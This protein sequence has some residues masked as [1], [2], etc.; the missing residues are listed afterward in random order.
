MPPK[1]KK[2]KQVVNKAPEAPQIEATPPG[3]QVAPINAVIFS[4]MYL[5]AIEYLKTLPQ[6]D[7]WECPSLLKIG[8]KDTETECGGYMAAFNKQECLKALGG[9]AK[10]YTSAIPF[11]WFD[12]TFSPTPAVALSRA[13]LNA[14]IIDD[15]QT[16]EP[17]P[18]QKV[19]VSKDEKDFANLRS[20]SP[21]EVMI[22][23]VCNFV[24]RH[25]A[26]QMKDAD[27][28]G[29]RRLLYSIP[30]TFIAEDNKDKQF[31]SALQVRRDIQK[32]AIL[33][34]RSGSQVVD[35]IM[36][37]VRA[38]SQNK[39]DGKATAQSILQLY[40][41]NLGDSGKE[42]GDDDPSIAMTLSMVQAAMIIQKQIKDVAAINAVMVD[43]S[44]TLLEKSPFFTITNLS[45][46]AKK[47]KTNEELQWIIE[48]IFDTVLLVQQS[49]TIR[50]LSPKN[51]TGILDII[52][53]QREMKIELLDK[54]LTDVPF[55]AEQKAWLKTC[56]SSPSELRS[57]IGYP[58]GIRA[59]LQPD[60]KAAFLT[61][62]DAFAEKYFNTVH[63]WVYTQEHWSD[64]E[65][66]LNSQRT[67]R[68][69][70]KLPPLSVMIETL[71]TDVAAA[72]AIVAAG[73]DEEQ[74][75][76]E[77]DDEETKQEEALAKDPGT[78]KKD[79]SLDKGAFIGFRFDG[80]EIRSKG[81][82]TQIVKQLKTIVQECQHTVDR[83]C[84][85]KS[86]DK[87]DGEDT[88]ADYIRSSQAIGK[89]P[90]MRTGIFYEVGTSGSAQS[91]AEKNAPPFR[92]EHCERLVRGVLNSRCAGQGAKAQGISNKDIFFFYDCK[93][94]GNHTKIQSAFNFQKQKMDM[95]VPRTLMHTFRQASVDQRGKRTHEQAFAMNT[96]MEWQQCLVITKETL[97]T[98]I[99]VKKRKHFEGLN[100]SG[101]IGFIDAL[102]SDSP[103]EFKATPEDKTKIIGEE[104]RLLGS[105]GT[106]V[107]MANEPGFQSKPGQLEPVFFQALPPLLGLEMIHSYNLERICHLTG[108]NG[109][110]AL[111][112]CMTRT[113]GLFICHTEAHCHALRKHV[114]QQLFRMKQTE[115]CDGIY[116][117]NLMAILSTLPKDVDDITPE[118]AGKSTPRTVTTHD[119]KPTPSKAEGGKPAKGTP[120]SVKDAALSR[121]AK[122]VMTGKKKKK[123]K[124]SK[125]AKKDAGEE[126]EDSDSDSAA[127]PSDP[128]DEDD[129]ETL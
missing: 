84:S 73:A 4:E 52:L 26:G 41:D 129:G 96:S 44:E 79:T 68:D 77:S 24:R 112:C 63:K 74:Y 83:D 105:G 39:K 49:W 101:V 35:E 125:K 92:K 102:P 93:K 54:V 46:M 3:S 115:I 37:L 58:T 19:A 98:G 22:A 36:S 38:H 33:V 110:L 88:I 20:L 95:A 42:N 25:K 16:L 80:T 117:P 66:H 51:A 106:H 45:A 108:G 18:L 29:F 86:F 91:N 99:E 124:K 75:V 56:L 69:V 10:C 30:V 62:S 15:T 13:Q 122:G 55:P 111:T 67:A 40:Q 104:N 78:P 70:V 47:S 23:K 119:G 53:F 121:R 128:S 87:Q 107:S 1:A 8:A 61:G 21:E 109:W 28:L 120:K 90:N 50:R 17:F 114:I 100:N 5:P 7:D 32:M 126:S 94:D 14:A 27:T 48:I 60:K 31:F 11:P 113:P 72:N 12:H 71:K 2:V 103:L 59:K 123:G 43:A 76:P 82:S 89:C 97:G 116:D 9:G 34:R 81:L 64:I 6:F 118:K 85:F 127:W 65:A 57:T